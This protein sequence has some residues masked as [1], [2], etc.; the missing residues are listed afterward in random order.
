MRE[1]VGLLSTGEKG[2]GDSVDEGECER[3]VV[4][5]G[6]IVYQPTDGALG[7]EDHGMGTLCV[8]REFDGAMTD[9]IG[10]EGMERR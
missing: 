2:N 9:V 10:K 3:G 1:L 7:N 5:S 6:G 4:L 8:T